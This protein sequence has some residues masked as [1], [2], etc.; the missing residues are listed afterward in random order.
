MTIRKGRP[1]Q[2]N[3]P[4]ATQHIGRDG[5]QFQDVRDSEINIGDT[6]RGPLAK[7]AAIATIVGTGIAIAAFTHPGASASD[8]VPPAA[9]PASAAPVYAR[10]VN[11]GSDGVYTYPGPS[12]GAHFP[13]G[14]FD[15]TVVGV[16]CQDRDGE[17]VRDRDPVAGQPASWAVWDKL[18][19]GRWIPDMW[20]SL[21][22]NPGE[23][24]P[25]N[26]PSC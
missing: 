15:G 24:P 11:S 2:H 7:M 8:H 13:D 22:K 21:P 14:Y 6:G 5:N 4:R 3:R 23:T 19:T 18:T 9:G 16:V 25:D 12:R 17:A 1:A 10:I 20:T 26:L